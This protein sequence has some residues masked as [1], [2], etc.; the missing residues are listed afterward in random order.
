ME[1]QTRS[2][3]RALRELQNWSVQGNPPTLCQP[4]ANLSPTLCQPFLP[5]SLQAPLSADP[6][7]GFR[8][9]GFGSGQEVCFGLSRPDPGRN[10]REQDGTWRG[11]DG[12]LEG[13]LGSR[14]GP[15]R[16]GMA[17]TSGPGWT[18]NTGKQR[19]LR[20]QDGTCTGPGSDPDEVWMAPPET[21]T[22]F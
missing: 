8:N 15:G 2:S 20:T 18:R 10:A 6:R 7:R 16:A 21:V 22:D 11:W 12:L 19:T 4:F 9:A 5:T 1:S 3:K 14:M 17:P 13:T